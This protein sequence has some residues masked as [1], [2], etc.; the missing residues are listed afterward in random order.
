VQTP[1]ATQNF[2][3]YTYCLNNPLTYTDPDG[4]WVVTLLVTL[5][6]MW[7]NT[8]ATND[9][10][11]NPLKWDWNSPKTYVSLAQSGF[12]GYKMGSAAEKFTKAKI[13]D[14]RVKKTLKELNNSLMTFQNNSFNYTASLQEIG[15][16]GVNDVSQDGINFIKSWESYVECPKQLECDAEGIITVGYGHWIQPGENFN[17][18]LTKNQSNDL[19]LK[20]IN[21]KAVIPI[22]KYVLA[23]LNQNQFDALASYVYNVGPGNV[24]KGKQFINCLNNLDYANAGCEIDIIRNTAGIIQPGLVKRR[25]FERLLWE[26]GIFVF[27]K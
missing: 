25:Y 26:F 21:T 23:P 9:W 11:F 13:N 24:L 3:R 5:A 12:S 4:E 1:D 14:F 8:S 10:E 16:L 22:R 27:N 6:N 15:T 2:N 17:A 19:L 7:I 20:D 18:G